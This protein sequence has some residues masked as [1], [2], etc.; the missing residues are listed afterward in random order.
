MKTRLLLALAF[1][2]AIAISIIG[3]VTISDRF[4]DDSGGSATVVIETPP[5]TPSGVC[6]AYPHLR[7]ACRST[8]GEAC[9]ALMECLK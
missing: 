4:F 6:A 1:L 7:Y 5:E 9:T 3:S 2:V 8:G